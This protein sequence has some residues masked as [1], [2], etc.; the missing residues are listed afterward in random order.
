MV[1]GGV[2]RDEWFESM[3]V[4]RTDGTVRSAG[5]AVIELMAVTPGSRRKMWSARLLPWVRKQIDRDYRRLAARRG[6][7]SGK[8]D[9]VER[10]VVSPRWVRP[11]D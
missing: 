7:L 9:D 10:T 5:D 6:E 4:V 8:V 2:P 3:H 11:P 1:D